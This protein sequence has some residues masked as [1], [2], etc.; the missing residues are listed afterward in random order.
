MRIGRA[1]AVVEIR[2]FLDFLEYLDRLLRRRIDECRGRIDRLNRRNSLFFREIRIGAAE[3]LE[4]VFRTFSYHSSRSSIGPPGASMF[5]CRAIP[6]AA[7][8]VATGAHLISAVTPDVLLIQTG[9]QM[10]FWLAQVSFGTAHIKEVT[11]CGLG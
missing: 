3:R 8:S 5:A 2:A 4:R 6:S 7:P 9:R 11:M 10:D 1:P